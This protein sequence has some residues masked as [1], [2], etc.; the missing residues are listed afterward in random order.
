MALGQPMDVD[1]LIRKVKIRQISHIVHKNVLHYLANLFLIAVWASN[2][3]ILYMYSRTEQVSKGIAHIEIQLS[4]CGEKEVKNKKGADFLGGAVN[5][6]L[7]ASAGNMG[8]IPGPG[9]SHMP[10]SN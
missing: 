5:K 3:I 1:K 2:S 6:N 10:R 4:H 7:S 9:R 8:L